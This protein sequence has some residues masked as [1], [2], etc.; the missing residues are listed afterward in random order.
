MSL[1]C[2][3]AGL[4][5]QA[6][7]GKGGPAAPH[8]CGGQAVVLVLHREHSGGASWLPRGWGRRFGLHGLFWEILGCSRGG[9]GPLEVPWSNP[10]S[11]CS[12]PRPSSFG[13]SPRGVTLQPLWAQPPAQQGCTDVSAW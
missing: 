5:T 4:G 7:K 13:K 11:G 6:G 3:A 8:S 2:G 12:G 10:C 9:K 1:H